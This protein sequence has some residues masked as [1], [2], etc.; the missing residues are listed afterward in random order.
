M[1]PWHMASVFPLS[2]EGKS[3]NVSADLQLRKAAQLLHSE[4]EQLHICTP[5]ET[6]WQPMGL[7]GH[8]QKPLRCVK[9]TRTMSKSPSP[10]MQSFVSISPTCTLSE[11]RQGGLGALVFLDKCHPSNSSLACRYSE[12]LC[13][14][15]LLHFSLLRISLRLGY[16]WSNPKKKWGGNKWVVQASP[17][18]N[19]EMREHCIPM[20]SPLPQKI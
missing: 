19:R 9:R 4:S 18:I 6:K 10:G 12:A 17:T 7:D 20:S 1:A 8:W 14:V 15:V 16:R 13:A 5:S 2:K 3:G 11:V